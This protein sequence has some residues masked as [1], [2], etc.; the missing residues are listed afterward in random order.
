MLKTLK[1]VLFVMKQALDNYKDNI[2]INIY[3]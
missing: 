1:K 3:H 2:Q